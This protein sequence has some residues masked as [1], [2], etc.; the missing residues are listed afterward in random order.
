MK[1]KK[2]TV[3]ALLAAGGLAGAPA[4]AQQAKDTGFYLGGGL[5]YSKNKFDGADFT[6]GIPGVAESADDNDTGYKIFGGYKFHRNFSVEGAYTNL[7]D[8]SYNYNAGVAGTASLGYDVDAWSLA[9]VGSLPVWQGLSVLGKIGATRT[10][11]ELTLNSAT[12]PIGAAVVAAGI[13]VGTSAK[14]RRT[15]LLWGVGAQYDFAPRFGV[16][17]EYEDYGKV[18]DSPNTGRAKAS[19]WSANVLVRF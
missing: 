15:D 17:V 16:R 5:G 10:T 14:K 19:L 12:G 8:F 2:L 4:F 13:P 9:L 7:G 6:L 3:V 11:A 18:G 1:I